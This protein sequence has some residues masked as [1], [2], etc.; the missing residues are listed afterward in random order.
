MLGQTEI[1]LLVLVVLVVAVFFIWRSRQHVRT[2]K[3]TG[4]IRGDY[5]VEDVL[6]KSG[7]KE[8]PAKTEPTLAPETEAKPAADAAPS[9]IPPVYDVI[10]EEEERKRAAEEAARANAEEV[11]AVPA[12][13]G[14]EW[15]AVDTA[16][17]WVLD[18]SAPEKTTFKMGGLDSLRRELRALNLKLPL[19]VW[20]RS[21][22]DGLYYESDRLQKSAD[23]IVV[24]VVLANRAAQ[25]D[26]LTASSV[27]QVLETVATQ[28]DINVRLSQEI[29]EAVAAA[30]TLRQFIRYY[31]NR[32]ELEVVPLDPSVDFTL[33]AVAKLAA[34]SGFEQNRGGFEYRASAESLSPE[35]TLSLT[36]AETR[37]LRLSLDL[38]LVHEARGDFSTFL[39]LAN[40]FCG[41]LHAALSDCNG[42]PIGTAEAMYI[43][44]AA[45]ERMR[46][47]KKAGVVAGSERARLL[48]SSAS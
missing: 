16:L 32:L 18:I 9:D 21:A 8:A 48:F 24:A 47:M 31:D 22:E 42:K 45:R 27:L 30:K 20:T 12:A 35:I 38:P 3:K 10:E 1:V 29:P 46:A 28:Y 37:G 39:R 34:A 43:E 4:K 17:E 26:E 2:A 5:A 41:H 44:E 6:M 33:D 23:H 13:V 40:H 19:F 14:S 7:E 11:D 36:A 15:P 25:L